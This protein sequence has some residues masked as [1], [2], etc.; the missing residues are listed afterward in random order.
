MIDAECKYW[1]PDAF[2]CTKGPH[3]YC[4]EGADDNIRDLSNWP[5]QRNHAP[6]GKLLKVEA[7]AICLVAGVAFWTWVGWMLS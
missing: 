4:V 7:F 2:T 5:P 3:C 1:N 6:I